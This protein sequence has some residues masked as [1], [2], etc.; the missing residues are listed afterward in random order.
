MPITES[1]TTRTSF[2]REAREPY[3]AMAAFDRSIDLDPQL[4]ELIKIRASIINGCAYCIDMHTYE[5]RRAGESDRRMHA[6]AAW[7]ESP[8]FSS[9]ERA[10]L[11]LTDSITLIGDDGVPD[12]VYAVAASEFDSSELAQ[13]AMAIVAINAWN[14]IAVTSRITFEPPAE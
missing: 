9:R 1:P 7:R 11:A 14:R 3:R 6:L 10:A 13:L 5:A 8:L 12:D 2:A 4:R